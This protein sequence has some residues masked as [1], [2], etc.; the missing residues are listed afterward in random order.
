MAKSM[1]SL[2][3]A[4]QGELSAANQG[5]EE[6]ITAYSDTII[7][8]DAL[9]SRTLYNMK[10]FDAPETLHAIEYL[11]GKRHLFPEPTPEEPGLSPAFDMIRGDVY[12]WRKEYHKAVK[13][14]L[15]YIRIGRIGTISYGNRA[16]VLF[17]IARIAE[18]YLDDPQTAGEYYKRIVEETPNDVRSYFALEKAIQ[19]GAVSPEE[20]Q[21]LRLSGMDDDVI[22]DLFSTHGGKTDN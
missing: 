7:A 14:Y 13:A 11:E 8:Q 16:T 21:Q 4:G 20:V 12:F 10:A 17:K 9:L 3:L 2:A 19:Y 22:Q 1:Q 5:W 18:E 6:V 15:E